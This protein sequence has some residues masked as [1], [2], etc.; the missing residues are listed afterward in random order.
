MNR[1]E[2]MEAYRG[3]GYNSQDLIKILDFKL[4]GGTTRSLDGSLVLFH[5]QG[6][7][8]AVCYDGVQFFNKID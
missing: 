3:T 5:H 1:D 8:I 6:L 4:D 7:I 2:I